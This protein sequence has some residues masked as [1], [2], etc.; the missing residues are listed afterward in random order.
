MWCKG[1]TKKENLLNWKYS[2]AVVQLLHT[3]LVGSSNLSTSTRFLW[4]VISLVVKP[5]VVIPL[6]RVRFSYNS[7]KKFEMPRWTNFG[8]VASLKRKRFSPF[9]S[10]VGYQ[11]TKVLVLYIRNRPLDKVCGCVI[12]YAYVKKTSH[13][14][15]FLNVV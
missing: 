6:S 11:E 4:G 10:E 5:R 12:L 7:P 2:T 15:K 14:D 1:S 8:K 13:I 3:E 9:E